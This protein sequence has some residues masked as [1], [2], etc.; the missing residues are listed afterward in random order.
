M[1]KLALLLSFILLSCIVVPNRE[2]MNINSFPINSAMNYSM[3][4]NTISE[5]VNMDTLRGRSNS[6]S[7]NL[8]WEL[9]TYSDLSSV[10]YVDRIE[11]QNNNPLWA[12][13]TEKQNF[14]LSYT[15]FKKKMSNN[16]D[17]ANST[18]RQH[19][20]YMYREYK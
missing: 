17:E 6:L 10:L 1:S 13:Q 2:I 3:E 11:T 20:F 15:T 4:I 19:I 8:L 12:N 16:Q 14:Q 7:S 18:S 5:D 9:S